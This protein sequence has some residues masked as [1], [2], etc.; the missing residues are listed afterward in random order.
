MIV[1]ARFAR[2]LGFF[3]LAL[4]SAVQ[5]GA[6]R[7]PFRDAV[8]LALARST[9]MGIAVADLVRAHEGYLEA[10]NAYIPQVIFGSGLAKSWGFPMSIE[11]SAPSIFNI[12]SQSSLWNPGQRDFIRAARTEWLASSMLSTD[13][14]AQT[15]LD[16]ALVYLQL[17]SA[18]AKLTE[19]RKASQT[20]QKVQYVTQQRIEAGVDAKVELTRANLNAARIRMAI[21]VAQSDADLLR[22]QLSQL[23]GFPMAE[24]ETMGSSIPALPELSLQDDLVKRAVENSAAVKAA[25]AEAQAKQLRASGERKAALYPEVDLVGSY[26]LFTKYN[27]FDL[28]FQRFSRNNATFGV[29]IHFPFL[30]YPQRAHAAAADAEALRAK[31]EAEQTR[32]KVSNETLKLQESIQ[33]LQAARD[34]A[35]LEYELAQAN[36]DTTQAKLDNGQANLRDVQNAQMGVSDKLS[37]VFDARLALQRAQLQLMRVSGDLE[38]WAKAVK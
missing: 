12:N 21:A 18:D 36:V 25:E 14:R 16:T 32:N 10:R 34:V 9:G 17:D 6:Q 28:Y 38:E 19:L 7:L 13:Q 1:R 2:A 24:L 22:Q 3:V 23:T 4:V 31:S 29:A 5:A 15:I 27:N 11:G 37:S 8:D 33:Q 20:A 26:G 35:Q 30:N